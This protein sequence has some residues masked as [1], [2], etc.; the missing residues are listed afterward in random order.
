MTTVCE[1][2]CDRG[3]KLYSNIC[4]FGLNVLEI[5]ISNVHIYYTQCIYTIYYIAII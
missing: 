1:L 3:V 2:Q 4:S 5:Y